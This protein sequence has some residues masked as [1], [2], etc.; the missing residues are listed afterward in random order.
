M[1]PALEKIYAVGKLLGPKNFHLP[2]VPSLIPPVPR[3]PDSAY[4]SSKAHEWAY[5]FMDPKMTAADKKALE[6]WEIPLFGTPHSFERY[7]LSR[8]ASR[9]KLSSVKQYIEWRRFEV[10]LEPIFSSIEMALEVAVPDVDMESEDYLILRN[11]GINYV[12]MH[13][14]ILPFAKEFVC[15]KLLNLPVL[16]LLS[17][18]KVE[19]FQSAADKVCNMVMDTKQEF[20]YYHNILIAQARGEGFITGDKFDGNW[21]LDTVINHRRTGR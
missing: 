11:A 5:K 20:M 9:P 7:A 14:D 12:S 16:L 6:D 10:L 3:H 15:N 2:K 4:A 18:P 8:M 19:T 17:D 1:A 13:N 21:C